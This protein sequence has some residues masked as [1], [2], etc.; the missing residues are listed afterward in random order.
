VFLHLTFLPGHKVKHRPA[1]QADQAVPRSSSPDTTRLRL[2]TPVHV[3]LMQEITIARPG[4]LLNPSPLA[5]KTAN[6]EIH[7]LAFPKTTEFLHW[8]AC[9]QR[10]HTRSSFDE[11][12]Q[13]LKLYGFA[14][15]K[16][17]AA[18]KRFSAS[19]VR[20]QS[21]DGDG[22]RRLHVVLPLVCA[23]PLQT[24]V[25]IHLIG[26]YNVRICQK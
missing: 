21:S 3:R 14:H 8:K 24:F 13:I 17:K 26:Q 19:G 18:T 2:G 10:S 20:S 1:L 6:R 22:L 25:S 4:R 12:R 15:E 7:S 11:H 23:D 16:I 9:L 5:R